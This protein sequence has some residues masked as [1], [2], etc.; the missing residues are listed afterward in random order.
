MDGNQ[1][2]GARSDIGHCTQHE[3]YRFGCLWCRVTDR[4]LRRAAGSAPRP[5]FDAEIVTALHG[6]A[7]RI[8]DNSRGS[9]SN[10]GAHR[11]LAAI[12]EEAARMLAA[13][14]RPDLIAEVFGA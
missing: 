1:S 12:H 11:A 10:E 9:F 13:L 8:E 5:S 7:I 6:F 2:I 3:S 4:D 14:N